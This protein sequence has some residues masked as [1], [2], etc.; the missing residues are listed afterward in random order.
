[1]S[2]DEK[3]EHRPSP[4]RHVGND[5][6]FGSRQQHSI[7]SSGVASFSVPGGQPPQLYPKNAGLNGIETPVVPLCFVVVFRRLAVVAKHSAS[8]RDAIVPS[9]N[10]TRFPASAEIFSRVEAERGSVANRTGPPPTLF[11]SR[12]I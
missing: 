2:N 4:I 7:A 9:R 1:N 6:P 3:V 8:M 11:L 12:E 10:R 5:R